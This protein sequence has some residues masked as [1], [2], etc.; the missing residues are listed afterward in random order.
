M[1]IFHAFLTMPAATQ[2]LAAAICG[3]FV[4]FALGLV[5]G[6]GSIL[7]VPLMLYVVGLHNPHIAIGTA[8]LAVAINAYLNLIPHARSGSVR[9]GAAFAFAASGVV[10]ATLGSSVGKQIDGQRLIVYFAMLMLFVAAL[11]L[12]GQ[13][14]PACAA[15]TS[16]MRYGRVCCTGI[17]AGGLSGFFGIGGG[18]LVVPGLML[19]ARL[20][21]IEAIGTSLFAVGSFGLTTAANYA[22]SGQVD[23]VIA[24]EFVAGGAIGGWL[25]ARSAARL[26][27]LRGVLNS[28]FA[29][30][31]VAAAAY[32]L[33]R[34][35]QG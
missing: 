29:A 32:I 33:Y 16:P 21:I 23:W 17:G 5:G 24:C 2:A 4:S 11:M 30:M 12:R 27:Q 28:L 34:S 25:G 8:A 35:R 7:A 26:A 22:M 20:P 18:F 31:I 14:R 9:W 3:A 19:S 1:S 13:F 6:G 10:G 15:D